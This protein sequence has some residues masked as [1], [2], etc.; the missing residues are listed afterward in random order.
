MAKGL[1]ELLVEAKARITEVS[2]NDAR[3]LVET[4][5]NALA[6]DVREAAELQAGRIP[7]AVLF[8]SQNREIDLGCM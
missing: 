2:V 1:K 8:F 7:G 5:S 4:D 6:L 3:T